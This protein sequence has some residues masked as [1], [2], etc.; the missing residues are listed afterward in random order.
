MAELIAEIDRIE[1]EYVVV[2]VE[3]VQRTVR[4]GKHEFQVHRSELLRHRQESRFRDM[5]SD[6][7]TG[8]L[9]FDGG[10]HKDEPGIAKFDESLVVSV[11]VDAVDGLG[12]EQGLEKESRALGIGDGKGYVTDGI[13]HDGCLA[14]ARV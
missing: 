13:E 4:P 2:I 10:F 14:E 7:V 8:A 9:S 6:M 5:E 11:F 1:F 3:E 12:C